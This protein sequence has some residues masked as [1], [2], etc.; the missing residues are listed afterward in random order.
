MFIIYRRTGGVLALL[1]LVAV[2]LTVTVLTAA[3]GAVVLL[4]GLAIAATVLV[5]RAVLPAS[6]RRH[7]VPPPTPWPLETIEASVVT[8]TASSDEHD[9]VDGCRH[10]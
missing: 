9:A 6:W 2:V 1:T 10:E 7:T 3:V 5:V 8:P 4:V